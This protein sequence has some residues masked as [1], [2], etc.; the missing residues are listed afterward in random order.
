MKIKNIEINGFRGIRYCIN[1]PLD[2]TQSVLLYGENGSGKSSITD[3]IEWFYFDRVEHLSKREIGNKGLPALRNMFLSEDDD[4]YI[5]ISFTD[6]KIDAIKVLTLNQSKLTSEY[7]NTSSEFFNYITVSQKENL[8]LR[9]KDLLKFILYTPGERVKEI[10]D[11]IGFSEVTKT[12]NVLKKAVNNLNKELK[13][14]NI[15]NQISN[16]QA[17]IF[18]QI[19]Q[20]INTDQQYFCAIEELVAPLNLSIHIEDDQSIEKV[21]ELIKR[22]ED[23]RAIR[24]QVSYQ[25]IIETLNNINNLLE[26]MRSFYISFY[27]QYQKILIDIDKFKKM[28][29]EGLLS[30]G[31]KILEENIFEDNRCPLCLQIKNREELIKELRKRIEE[32]SVFKKEKEKMEE[33]KEVTQR[34]LQSLISHL[35]SI[36]KEEGLLIPENKEIQEKI[37]QMKNS[38]VG[39]LERLSKIEIFTREEIKGPEEIFK[40]NPDII[41]GIISTL[42]KKM[43]HI[44]YSKKDDKKFTISQKIVLVRQAYNEIRTL[45]KEAEVL[46]RQLKSM[47]LIFNVFTKKQKEAISS[48]LKE[49]STDINEYYLFMNGSNEVDEIELIPVENED[50]LTGVTI[51]YKFHGEVVSPPEKYLS[52]S[53]LNCLGICLFLASVKVFNQINKF[54]ILDDV[55]SSFDT[56]H[57]LRFA[58]LL[59]EKFSDY[60][61]F[62][63]THEKSWYEYVASVVKGENWFI[64]EIRRDNNSRVYIDIPTLDLKNRIEQ[65]FAKSNPYDLGNMIRR[66]LERLLKE[67]CFELEVKV[68]FLFNDQNEKRMVGELLSE[69]RSHLKKRI[70]EIKDA[71]VFDKLRDSK[72]VGDRTSHDSSFTESIPDL[73]IFYEDVIELENL[74]I[75]DKCKKMISRRKYYD[76]VNKLVRCKCGN[77][78]Y[79]WKE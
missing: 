48:F 14:K 3:A 37:E 55:I 29:L 42:Q 61:I 56:I 6:S 62:L 11:I 59:K 54:F 8:I 27:E 7:S 22:P 33:E 25:N 32:L 30:E 13:I 10:S 69:L 16:K 4:A 19:G 45:K 26:R 60:Q 9:Y 70:P 78:T 74:F 66:Y 64:S 49:I 15:N 79:S 58:T 52:E 2:S 28:S 46:D 76:P 21:L 17:I 36:L 24:L 63:F 40:I 44:T 43:E 1:L 34:L 53:H 35:E 71:Q 20:N 50:E 18:A 47:Q 57:R 39:E 23:E 51:Q 38:L 73:K 65:K 67:I 5:K 12:K 75:C 41:Q 77:K 72:F 31:L 68:K